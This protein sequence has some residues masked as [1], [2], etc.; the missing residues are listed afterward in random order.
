M[1]QSVKHRTSAQVMISRFAGLSPT[2]GS[3]LTAR[4]LE[5]ASDSG[6]PSV[7]ALP[8]SHSV[9]LSKI[10]KR[11]KQL[12]KNKSYFCLQQGWPDLSVLGVCWKSPVAD[13]GPLGGLGTEGI[14]DMVVTLWELRA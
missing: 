6:S 5:P 13:K 12:K 3:V 14:G 1:A 7:S 4:S 10:N 2:L 9:S 11:E 8:H